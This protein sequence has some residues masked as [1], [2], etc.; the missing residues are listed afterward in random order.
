[1]FLLFKPLIPWCEDNPKIPFFMTTLFAL[2]NSTVLLFT[3]K[4]GPWPIHNK[5]LINLINIFLT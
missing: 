4:C 5:K 1:M 2:F 3:N